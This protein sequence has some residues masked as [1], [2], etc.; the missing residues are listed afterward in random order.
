MFIRHLLLWFLLFVVVWWYMCSS[1]F[2]TSDLSSPRLSSMW[3]LAPPNMILLL[4]GSLCVVSGSFARSHLNSLLH[5][6]SGS[7]VQPNIILLLYSSHHVVIV[8]GFCF[9]LIWALSSTGFLHVVILVFYST[10]SY[11]FPTL[12]LFPCGYCLDILLHSI[13]SFFSPQLF[14]IWPFSILCP[15][16][17]Y[18]TPSVSLSLWPI[19]FHLLKL[20]VDTLP[21]SN[22]SKMQFLFV[23]YR[24]IK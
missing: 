10:S 5:H 23:N 8:W 6:F 21:V 3:S 4:Y 9:I 22:C 12:W 7:F 13:W 19:K 18:K 2:I 1:C 11:L 15:P 24:L 17:F 14:S 20:I 16:Y